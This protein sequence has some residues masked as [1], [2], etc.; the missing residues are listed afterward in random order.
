ME[1]IPTKYG[2]ANIGI[3]Y[4]TFVY[5]ASIIVDD[6]KYNFIFKGTYIKGSFGE[7]DVKNI[8]E[9]I[10]LSDFERTSCEMQLKYYHILILDAM[11]EGEVINKPLLEILSDK[12]INIMK[13][14][15]EGADNK[16][17]TFIGNDDFI[18]LS[19][20]D[21][22]SIMMDYRDK[23]CNLFHGKITNDMYIKKCIFILNIYFSITINIIMNNDE[24]DL[25]GDSATK[26]HQ[27]LYNNMSKQMKRALN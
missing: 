20:V 4:S 7:I 24:I 1:K 27:L 18:T 21:E 3:N 15:R 5:E 9:K 17:I 26:L 2:I 12:I 13:T 8:Y 19:Y 25:S 11:V 6:V 16:D 14:I 23:K 10:I 22:Y